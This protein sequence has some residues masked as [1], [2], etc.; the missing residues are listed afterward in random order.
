M[1][2]KD[3][4]LVKG[5]LE[6]ATITPTDHDFPWIYGTV[7]RTEHFALVADYFE[8]DRRAM[9]DEPE[10]DYE[11]LDAAYEQMKADGVQLVAPEGVPVA[12]FLLHIVG[13]DAW[14]RYSDEPFDDEP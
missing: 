3:W 10:V 1:D 6:L 13:D 8:S 4:R 7:E 12:E 5:D 14:F 2:N 11:A 9:E